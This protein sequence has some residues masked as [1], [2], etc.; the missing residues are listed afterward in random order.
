[1][2]K[3][4]LIASLLLGLVLGFLYGNIQDTETS[5]NLSNIF[6][7]NR[8]L[9]YNFSYISLFRFSSIIILWLI[10][11]FKNQFITIPIFILRGLSIG[12]LASQIGIYVLPQAICFIFAYFFIVSKYKL[13]KNSNK[14]YF[15]N[16]LLAIGI[17]AFLNIF[18]VFFRFF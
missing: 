9:Y 16:F 6:Y 3:Y 13:V 12:F 11:F 14:E 15:I 10:G 7:E 17:I 18:E 2:D 4:L 1:M 5:V 8:Q